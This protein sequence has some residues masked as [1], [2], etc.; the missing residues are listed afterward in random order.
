[1]PTRYCVFQ[2]V[3]DPVAGERVNF[4]V[5]VYDESQVL[6]RFVNRWRRIRSFAGKD[7]AFLRHFA[8]RVEE[9]ADPSILLTDIG[10][11]ARLDEA[12][13]QRISGKWMHSIQLTEP[14]VG[15]LE[16]KRLLDQISTRFLREGDV[17]KREGLSRTVAAHAVLNGVRSALE[18]ESTELNADLAKE[19]L[20]P[21]GVLQGVLTSSRFDA[22]VANGAPVLAAH[23][24]S[25]QGQNQRLIE[26]DVNAISFSLSDVRQR[27][28]AMPLALVAI[29]PRYDVS[30]EY[31]RALEICEGLEVE[32]VGVDAVESWARPVVREYLG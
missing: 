17:R 5:V 15:L 7:V 16:P 14:R 9:S 27:Y 22:V 21:G 20:K 10:A 18:E 3:P 31:A 13:I 28:P 8:D 30:G 19:L 25:F 4:G 12:L 2:Y 11:V 32:V 1:M 23:G 29:P 26:T 6:V 24:L